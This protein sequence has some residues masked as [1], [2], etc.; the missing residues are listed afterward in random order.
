MNIS[1]LQA[2]A[3]PKP[4][5]DTSSSPANVL[6][7]LGLGVSAVGLVI[8]FVGVGEKGFKSLPLQLCGPGLLGLGSVMVVL[9]VL[10][11]FTNSRPGHRMAGADT[12]D[13]H[14]G[15]ENGVINNNREDD[16]RN[17]SRHS[18]MKEEQQ[19]QMFHSLPLPKVRS[20]LYLM[21]KRV[22]C[23][24]EFSVKS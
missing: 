12:E 1:I 23:T 13:S 9:R 7:Y 10:L 18:S 19:E 5:E 24:F 22:L 16:D 6:L 17:N 21:D 14:L 8:F 4:L 2:R 3:P 11:C 20:S 15:K